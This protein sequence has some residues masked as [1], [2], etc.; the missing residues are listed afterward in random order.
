MKIKEENNKSISIKK[1]EKKSMKEYILNLFNNKF[2][3]SPIF[4]NILICN[5]DTFIEDYQSFLLIM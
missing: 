2:K 4:Q 3:K 1:C 5:N